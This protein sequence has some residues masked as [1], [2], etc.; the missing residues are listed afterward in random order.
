LPRVAAALA[1]PL[2]NYTP[3]WNIIM[4]DNL[5]TQAVKETVSNDIN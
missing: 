2:P 1:P 3:V 4:I 5:F